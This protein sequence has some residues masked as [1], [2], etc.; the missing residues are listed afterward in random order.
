MNI[1]ER[2]KYLLNNIP[3]LLERTSPEFQ[4]L[5]HRSIPKEAQIRF[6]PDIYNEPLNHIRLLHITKRPF[7]KRIPTRPFIVVSRVRKV[8]RLS[9]I[10][11]PSSRE[12]V[13]EL[14]A[15]FSSSSVVAQ[16]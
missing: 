5:L 9:A 16:R 7:E 3:N 13:N 14:A 12:Q 1:L 11:T 6:I 2:F 8:F 4:P 15:M 10:S